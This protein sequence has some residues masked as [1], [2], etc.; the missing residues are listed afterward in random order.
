MKK[1]WLVLL[2]FLVFIQCIFT[3]CIFDKKEKAAADPSKPI[4][5]QEINESKYSD[6]LT[7]SGNI[8]PVQTVNLSYKIPGIIKSM[9]LNEG[10]FVEANDL[11]AVLDQQDY[12]LNVK[13]ADAELRSAK[14]QM[15]SEVP[16][17]I[18]QAKAQYELTQKTYERVKSLYEEGAASKSQM[19]EISAKL[20]ADRNT[21]QQALDA[22]EITSVKLEKAEV[23]RDLASSNLKDTYLYSP[24]KGVVLKKISEAGETIGQGHPLAVIGKVDEVD[25]EVGVSDEHINKIKNGQKTKVYIYGIGKEVKGTIAEVSALADSKTRTFPVKVRIANPDFKL[26][27]GMIG[28]VTIPLSEEKAVL[29]PVSSIIHLSE[30]PVVFV[31]SNKDQTVT[32][33]PIKTGK[34]IKDKVEVTK[35]LKLKE[36][37]VIE[38]QFK[39]HDG[40]KVAVEEMKS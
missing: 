34:I 1:K 23:A 35:G 19:D 21:Y 8:M 18:E 16:T 13:A 22:Q 14:L 29:I 32:K 26:K 9:S 25:I 40:D 39:L 37:I 12:E 33:R 11:V 20:T 15:E 30:G 24:I 38:G 17:K 2:I 31:Y 3:G 36:K 4:L 7:L 6:E 10:D 28:K 27:P 5:V